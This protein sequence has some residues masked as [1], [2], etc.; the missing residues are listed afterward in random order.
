MSSPLPPA[1]LR[2]IDALA[3][4]LVEDYLRAKPAPPQGSD[5]ARTNH[6]PFPPLDR[7]A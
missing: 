5:T 4:Q 3:A 7:A 1:T 2:L 6:A